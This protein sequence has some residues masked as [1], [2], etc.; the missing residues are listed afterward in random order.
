[1]R[2]YLNR[3][4]SR[5]FHLVVKNND[6]NKQTDKIMD[7]SSK[8]KAYQ[9]IMTEQAYLKRYPESFSDNQ[10][11]CRDCASTNIK[12]WGLLSRNDNKRVHS[13]QQC[14]QVLWR[15]ESSK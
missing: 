11:K 4:G 14:G 8:V 1:M 12:E 7:D 15:S 6:D 9:K 3:V 2:N 10:I 5:L 13:C